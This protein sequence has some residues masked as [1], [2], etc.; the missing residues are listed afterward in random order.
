MKAWKGVILMWSSVLGYGMFLLALSNPVGF[1]KF[2]ATPGNASLFSLF[3]TAPMMIWLMFWL[4]KTM[5]SG[6]DPKK[7]WTEDKDDF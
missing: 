1:G 6:K 5:G 7:W 3:I 2:I 4:K